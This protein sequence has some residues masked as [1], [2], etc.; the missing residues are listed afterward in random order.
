MYLPLSLG[1]VVFEDGIFVPKHVGVMSVP[2][3]VYDIV[4]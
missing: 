2:L 1:H 3:C 4:T